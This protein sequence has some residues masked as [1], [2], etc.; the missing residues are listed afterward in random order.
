MIGLRF[1]GP[2]GLLVDL[3]RL[4]FTYCRGYAVRL[5]PTGNFRSCNERRTPIETIH[6]HLTTWLPLEA[7]RQL[8]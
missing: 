7:K 3:P 8:S 1:R 6:T 5:K 2:N 4:N